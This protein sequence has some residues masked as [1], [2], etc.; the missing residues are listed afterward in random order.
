[1][2]QKPRNRDREIGSKC[3][4]NGAVKI[5]LFREVTQCRQVGRYQR[6]VEKY[7]LHLQSGKVIYY[8]IL[9]TTGSSGILIHVSQVEDQYSRG[10]EAM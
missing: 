7:Y 9:N 4:E 2:Q 3:S 10:P 8:F 1:V 6:F 5:T